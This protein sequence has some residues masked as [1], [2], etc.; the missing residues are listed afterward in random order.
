ME[1]FHFSEE[2]GIERFEPRPAATQGGEAVVW[3]IDT[4]H[5]PLH[6]LP[7]ECP[8]VT[9]WPVAESLPEHVERWFG[10]VS[11]RMVI[12]IEAAWLERL[13][14][15]RLY[16]YVFDGTGFEPLH[17]HGVHIAREAVTP[18]RVEPVGDLLATLT[19]S[20]VEL[21]I[22]PSLAPLGRAITRTSLHWSLIR[23]RNAQGWEAPDPEDMWPQM[24]DT[25]RA[26]RQQ[27]STSSTF[28]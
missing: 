27:R 19:A 13:H 14:T 23:M 6:Y 28:G 7:R 11:G 8:R 12:A 17:D 15:T 25:A 10:R 20:D 16:R 22:C 18:L 9:F 24:A 4:W 2:A 3:A 21:R 5:A 26:A 1:L